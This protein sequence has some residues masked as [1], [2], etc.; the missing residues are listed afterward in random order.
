VKILK[1]VKRF[2]ILTPEDELK[3]QFLRIEI[4][5]RTCYQSEKDKITKKTAEKFFRMLLR[6]GHESVLEHSSMT[7]KFINVSRGFTH[8]LVRHRL[9][10]FSQESTRYVDYAKK[11]KGVDIDRFEIQFVMPPHRN[12]YQEILLEDGRTIIPEDM[13][14]EFEKYYRGLRK[15][16]WAPEDARQ[17][18]PIGIKAEIVITANFREWRHIF[19]MRTPRSAHWEIR[20]VMGELLKEV[21]KI[22]PVIFDDFVEE[23]VDSKGVSYF[24]RG[25]KH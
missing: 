5:G 18:L 22:V 20:G 11:G 13:A 16:G 6:K 1:D 9:A 24:T 8:E 19:A 14:V 2:E 15:A 3:A 12:K 4:A 17:F 21:R 25:L 10:S 23:G 7:V